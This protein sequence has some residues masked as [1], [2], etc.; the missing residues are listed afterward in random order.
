MISRVI[1]KESRE[2]FTADEIFPIHSI[3]YSDPK[4]W[5]SFGSIVLMMKNGQQ[6]VAD[7]GD[8]E[9]CLQM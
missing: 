7:F 8:L 9:G 6:H 5:G 3:T 4:N 2:D 1:T